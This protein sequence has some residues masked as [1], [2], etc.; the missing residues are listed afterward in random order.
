MPAQTR[1]YLP[2]TPEEIIEVAQRVKAGGKF[3]FE[4]LARFEK[5][6]PLMYGE[7]LIVCHDRDLSVK[8]Y[9]GIDVVNDI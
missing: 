3:T 2:L 5:H 6:S 9:V 7:Y 1:D 8:R 4:E